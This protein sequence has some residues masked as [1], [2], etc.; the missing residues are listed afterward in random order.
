MEDYELGFE[1]YGNEEEDFL[2][3]DNEYL[4]KN[5][6]MGMD[7]LNLTKQVSYQVIDEKDMI[8]K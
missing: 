5:E 7:E 3:M 4:M 1:D 2:C 8:K 6:S